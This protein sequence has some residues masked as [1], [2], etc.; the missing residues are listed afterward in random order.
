MII[1]GILE[2]QYFDERDIDNKI[3]YTRDWNTYSEMAVAQVLNEKKR[4]N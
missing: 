4:R 2:V 3:N 1:E